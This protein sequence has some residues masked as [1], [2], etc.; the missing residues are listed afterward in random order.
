MQKSQAQLPGYLPDL[1]LREILSLALL[2]VNEG[3]HVAL[4]SKFHGNVHASALGLRF[5]SGLLLL[6]LSLPSSS[7]TAILTCSRIVRLSFC[8]PGV[9]WFLSVLASWWISVLL[10]RL[11]LKPSSKRSSIKLTINE[12]IIELN[13]IWMCNSLHHFNFINNFLIGLL[14]DTFLHLYFFQSHHPM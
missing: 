6:P 8:L 10:A 9:H 11:L 12:W 2:L 5:S 1:F 14:R 3:L 13:N 4:L 7:S